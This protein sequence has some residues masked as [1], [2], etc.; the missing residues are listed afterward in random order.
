MQ[1]SP[2][3]DSHCDEEV[4]LL[5]CGSGAAGMTASLVAAQEGLRVMMCEKH[6]QV[7]GTT[8]TSGGMA[9]IPG[10]HHR[11][12]DPHQDREAARTYLTSE[13]GNDASAEMIDAFLDSGPAAIAYLERHTEA[14]FMAPQPNPDYH[15]GIPGAAIVGRAVLPMPFD[16]RLLGDDFALVR[17]PRESLLV[18]GGMMVARRD[19]AILLRPF[20][21]WPSFRTASGMVS[22]YFADRLRHRR[23]TRLLLGNALIG[24]LLLSIRR[25]AIPLRMGTA[26]RGLVMDDGRVVGAEVETAGH[27]RHIRVRRGVVLATGGFA[28]SSRWR[29][30]LLTEYPVEHTLAFEESAGDGFDIAATAGGAVRETDRNP[31]FWAPVSVRKRPGGG[32]TVWMHGVLDRAK[33]GLIAVDRTGRRFVNEANSYHDF[34]MGMFRAGCSGTAP[35]YLVC[36]AAFIARYGLGIIQ[37]VLPRLGSHIRSGYLSVGR[38]VQELAGRIGIDAASLGATVAAYNQDAG[39]GVDTEFGK[40]MTTLNRHNGDP[41]QSPNPCMRPIQTPPFY[42]VAVY[43]GILGTSAGLETDR[44]GRVLGRDGA[45][46]A[47]LYACGNDMSSMMRGRYPGPGITLGPAITFAYRAAMHAA[48]AGLAASGHV[49]NGR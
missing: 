18:L 45:P 35:A 22:R 44:D 5:V 43:P 20:A 4:D 13:L 17:P 23:G 40:G 49:G 19:V 42:A 8:A 21:S 34:V 48:H 2:S 12:Q 3:A 31:V 1:P 6:G 25:K 7:G 16:G 29:K 28:G 36:D 39:R 10:N 37:P 27:R 46:I 14:K 41:A 38:T 11:G 33:P 26:L 15:S 32:E 30:A 24:R 9:W 47:G